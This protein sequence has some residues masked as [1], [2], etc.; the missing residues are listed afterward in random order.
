[1]AESIFTSQTP[2]T[3]NASDGAP[4]LTLCTLFTPAVDGTVTGIRWFFPATLPASNPIGLLW[5]WT[6]DASGTELARKTFSSPVAGAWNTILFDTPVAVTAGQY[7][8]A[9]VWTPDR[10]VASTTVF[11][12]A[13]I[14]NG[15]LIAPQSNNAIPRRNGRFAAGAS[16]AYPTNSSNEPNYFADVL[17]EAAGATNDALIAGNV[18][19]VGGSLTVDQL[20]DGV[21]AGNVPALMGSLVGDQLTDAVLTGNVPALIGSLTV[22]TLND[23]VVNGSLPAL[24][25]VITLD[26]D[27]NVSFVGSML[28]A[29]IGTLVMEADFVPATPNAAELAIQRSLTHQFILA[30]P[31]VVVLVPRTRIRQ[32]NGGYRQMNGPARESQVMRLIEQAPPSVVTLEDGTQRS[33]DYVLL[34]DWN[35]Q[36]AK[37]DVFSYEDDSLLVVELYH[38]NGYEIRASVTRQLDP[39]V[40]V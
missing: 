17:F 2:T 26:Q 8:Y 32:A 38:F 11:T 19:S 33:L 5:S 21:I 18:P 10:Y 20:Y 22:D 9:S 34:A 36:V 12:S 37:G 1:M 3:T 14:T 30:N 39:P 23:L 35:A 7:Y 31:S 24:A 6:S 15:N 27:L 25:G 40:T 4:G 28:P 29:V 16:P 13:G